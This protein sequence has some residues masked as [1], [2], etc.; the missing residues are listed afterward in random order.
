MLVPVF[1]LGRGKS[2]M[3]N[4]GHLLELDGQES[5]TF[6]DLTAEVLSMVAEALDVR[7]LAKLAAASRI[8]LAAARVELKAALQRRR[9]RR[10]DSNAV[11]SRLS[12][13][14][15][16]LVAVKRCLTGGG[17]I[18]SAMV[19]CPFFRLPD[20]LVS[21]PENAFNGCETLTSLKI[22]EGVKNIGD[23][24]FMG[25][26]KL[27][28]LTLPA[29]LNIIGA[30]ALSG[31]TALTNLVL[32]PAVTI[33]ADRAFLGNSSLVEL[34]LPASLLAIGERVF[35]GCTSLNDQYHYQRPRNQ[36][37]PQRRLRLHAC[38]PSLVFVKRSARL[39]C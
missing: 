29:S 6:T 26:T 5:E 8:C 22:P 12:G 39:E 3:A 18:S 4:A 32:P 21:I 17:Q 36:R 7:S 10:K 14:D 19:S 28:E 11:Q 16:L 2:A 9:Q 24:A 27:T 1:R 20:D 25:C 31:C 13:P 15:Q 37:S 30:D 34:R 33:I 35:E 23:G 38:L